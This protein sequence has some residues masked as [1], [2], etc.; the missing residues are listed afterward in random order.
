M[1][2]RLHLNEIQ[3]RQVQQ[4]QHLHA[5]LSSQM[6]HHNKELSYSKPETCYRT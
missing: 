1:E 6:P 4:P 3:Q 5:L 2:W